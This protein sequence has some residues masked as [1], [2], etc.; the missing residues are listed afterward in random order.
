MT[1]NSSFSLTMFRYFLVIPQFRARARFLF[2][3]LSYRRESAQK[4]KHQKCTKNSNDLKCFA[5]QGASGDIKQWLENLLMKFFFSIALGW[6]SKT[7][8]EKQAIFREMILSTD[9]KRRSIDDKPE[10][11]TSNEYYTIL[12]CPFCPA[13]HVW[14]KRV[15]LFNMLEKEQRKGKEKMLNFWFL[16][17]TIWKEQ[18]IRKIH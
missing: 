16:A 4:K 3:S 13:H 11:T 14:W 6:W 9:G 1:R 7:K 10:R 15:M 17:G 12:D 8:R 5:G 2:A 18:K